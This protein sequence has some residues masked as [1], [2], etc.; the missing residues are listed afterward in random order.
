[1]TITYKLVGITI[2]GSSTKNEIEDKNFVKKSINVSHVLDFF[3]KLGLKN[4]NNLKIIIDTEK[5]LMVPEKEYNLDENKKRLIY[6]FSMDPEIKKCLTEI[7]TKEISSI[8]SEELAKPLTCDE[9]LI[10]DKII[11]ITNQVTIELFENNDFKK[12]FEVYKNNPEMFKTFSSYIS[13]GNV[14]IDT[15]KFEESTKTDFSLEI[16]ELKKLNLD[17][18]ETYLLESLKK[19]NG[20]LNLTLRYIL[21]ERALKAE[22]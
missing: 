13:S 12:L 4:G 21:H 20:H 17:F 2:N 7:F 16:N 6:I 3:F 9:I 8:E 18:E 5:E 10:N 11:E 22:S 19:F 14:L 15:D 1:M